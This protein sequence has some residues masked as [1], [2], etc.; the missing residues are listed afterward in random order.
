MTTAVNI[1]AMRTQVRA[2]V[3]SNMLDSIEITRPVAGP[4]VLDPSTGQ[5][6]APSGSTVI[7]TGK[8]RVHPSSSTGTAG[9]GAGNIAQRQCSIS[10]PWNA[11][12]AYI[13][14]LIEVVDQTDVT[15]DNSWWRVIGVSG[16]GIFNELSSYTC[17]AWDKS[18]YWSGNG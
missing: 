5:L 8:A 7:Y 2:Y 18:S 3:E 14:D 12:D 15:V 9:T 11:P 16:A 13:D 17:E 6:A 10:V 4:L 1:A